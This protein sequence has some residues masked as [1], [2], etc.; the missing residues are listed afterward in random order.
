MS[1]KTKLGLLSMFAAIAGMETNMY[2]PRRVEPTEPIETDEE[3]KERLA[4]AKI[5]RYKSQG[6]TEYSYPGGTVW[7]LNQKSAD[8][9]AE[10]SG[11]L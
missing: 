6:L 11:W 9:K 5:E 2:S 7:A 8:K 1:I 4:K 3:R 10:R